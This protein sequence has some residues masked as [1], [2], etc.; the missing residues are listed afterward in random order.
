META[1]N[2][3]ISIALIWTLVAYNDN[4]GLTNS[5]KEG[6]SFPIIVVRQIIRSLKRRLFN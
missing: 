2:F 4:C 1:I 5:I 6:F 3:Y